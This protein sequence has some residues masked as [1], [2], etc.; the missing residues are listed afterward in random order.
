[1]HGNNGNFCVIFRPQG[2]KGT[3]TRPPYYMVVA[4]SMSQLP[5]SMTSRLCVVGAANFK[6]KSKGNQQVQERSIKVHV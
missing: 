1:M 4:S 6:Q 3:E 2:M 5:Q